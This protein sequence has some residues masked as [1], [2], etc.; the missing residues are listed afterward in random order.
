MSPFS[1]KDS[2]WTPDHFRLS[3]SDHPSTSDSRKGRR[4]P[5][6]DKFIMGPISIA[7]VC[8][9]GRLR[10]CALLV[11]LVL[12][13]LKG[14]RSSKTFIVS[15]VIMKGWHIKPHAK[16]RA[17]RTLERAGLVTIEW[18]GRRSPLV[19]LIIPSSTARRGMNMRC[20]GEA[21]P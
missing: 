15:N 1:L 11:G 5:T 7:W 12:W 19:T 18:R 3:S 20:E 6:Q 14:L 17:L 2:T 4:A 10:G 9:A 21:H 16:R 8:Q 13:Y